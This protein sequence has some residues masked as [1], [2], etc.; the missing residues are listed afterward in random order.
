MNAQ[1][2]ALQARRAAG[3]TKALAAL[4]GVSRRTIQHWIKGRKQPR[5][6]HMEALRRVIEEHREADRL[7]AEMGAVG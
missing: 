5:K 7:G 1:R 4:V 2:F 6:R 3:G